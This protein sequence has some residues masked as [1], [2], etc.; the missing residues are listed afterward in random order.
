MFLSSSSILLLSHTTSERLIHSGYTDNNFLFHFHTDS[1]YFYLNASILSL[2]FCT[3]PCTVKVRL[4]FDERGSVNRKK[5]IRRAQNES[6]EQEE[7][8]EN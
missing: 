8:E 5:E 7:E 6:E 1:S 4:L 2:V 3:L